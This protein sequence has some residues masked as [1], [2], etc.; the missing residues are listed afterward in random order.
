MTTPDTR[1]AEVLEKLNRAL[2]GALVDY[3]QPL[4][5]LRLRDAMLCY[6]AWRTLD[7]ERTENEMGEKERER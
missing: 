6:E 3:L 5:M 7:W 1:R 4:D 2:D